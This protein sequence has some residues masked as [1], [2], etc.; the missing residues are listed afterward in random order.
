[1][2]A[3]TL[4]IGLVF[5]LLAGCRQEIVEEEFQPVETHEQ[6][7][8]ALSFLEISDSLMGAAWIRAGERSLTEPTNVETP[9]EE[10]IVFDSHLPD[11]AGYRFPLRRGRRVTVE[12]ETDVD[13]YFADLFR[14]S[15]PDGSREPDPP[16]LVASRRAGGD[17]IELEARRDQFYVL[18]IQPE[19][20][21]G[22]YFR[23]R[24][25]SAASLAFPVEDAGP[26][27]ILSFYGDPRSGGTRI[28]EGVDIFAPRG[29]PLLATSEAIVHR[30]GW[31]DR[32]GN[33]VSLRDEKR[34][35]LIYYAHLEEQLVTQGQ[36]VAPGDVV[37]TVGNTGN[38]INTPPHLH[39]GIYQNN[40]RGAVDPWEYLVDPAVTEPIPAGDIQ[41]LR[42][43]YRIDTHGPVE[44]AVPPVPVPPRFVNRNPFTY[45]P[46]TAAVSEL[47]LREI[48]TP[49]A[50]SAVL[51]PGTAVQTIGSI[52]TDAD[53]VRV[54]TADGSTWI[55]PYRALS[56]A[57]VAEV[58]IGDSVP[59]IDPLSGDTI[60]RLDPTEP[61]R[62]LGAAGTAFPGD[63][64]MVVLLQS[65]RTGIIVPEGERAVS[66][67][68]ALQLPGTQHP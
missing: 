3:K 4:R 51:A 32:G 23:V 14:V 21:R 41:D 44:R 68:S 42:G 24:I 46:G 63:Q 8:E 65:G 64:A 67:I 60:A 53:H 6:Y 52:G 1:M 10:T 36:R 30:V 58:E 25:T 45:A 9:V 20:L 62:I 47:G 11:A 40:W 50:M 66:R 2:V 15:A 18:R 54:R 59:V 17:T 61:V 13:R 26:Q 28:H 55:M 19:L 16:V 29:T 31:R 56:P 43:W 39:I 38:A 12:I 48:P 35:L 7:R 27:N 37:G 57:T 22:G 5:L 33:I 49:P 34:D